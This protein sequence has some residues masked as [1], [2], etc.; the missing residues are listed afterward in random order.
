[1]ILH[2]SLHSRCRSRWEN[3]DR[4][5]YPF[6][7]IKFM[8]LVVPSPCETE[9]YNKSDYKKPINKFTDRNTRSS[10]VTIG[11]DQYTAI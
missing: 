2:F 3:L 8:G 7:P 11:L 5:Q 1:M 6:Q 10:Y 4:G 9:P